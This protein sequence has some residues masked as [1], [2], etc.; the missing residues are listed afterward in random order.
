MM[1]NERVANEDVSHDLIRFGQDC[2]D[3][4]G[5]NV[6]FFVVSVRRT[7]D[8]WYFLLVFYMV[9]IVFS[10]FIDIVIVQTN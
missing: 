7:R 1:L 5:G 2:W 9:V 10:G 4:T 6:S 8:E 3:R